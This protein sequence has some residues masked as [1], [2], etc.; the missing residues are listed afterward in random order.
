MYRTDLI[1]YYVNFDEEQRTGLIVG[2]SHDGAM[3]Q[4]NWEAFGKW[5]DEFARG[6]KPEERSQYPGSESR[7]VSYDHI[8][9]VVSNSP[10]YSVGVVVLQPKSAKIQP[11]QRTNK[12]SQNPVPPVAN[13]EN[14]SPTPLRMRSGSSQEIEIMAQC[15][16]FDSE[17][18]LVEIYASKKEAKA[19]NKGT[20]LV[21]IDAKNFPEGG[22]GEYETV[23]QL[24]PPK[25]K[26]VKADGEKRTRGPSASLTGQYTVVKSDAGRFNEEDARY[27][28]HKA[29]VENNNFEDYFAATPEKY[30][31]L[32]SGGKTV[33]D[34]P[35]IFA[36]YALRRGWISV[37]EVVV[38]DDAE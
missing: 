32:T 9:E 13:R 10:K 27:A 1:G 33:T 15:A 20:D 30:D 25:E 16:V 6:V 5:H 22:I 7:T 26:P 36:R 12:P 21:F 3:V 8:T 35:A 14:G 18:E 19:H 23:D 29:L 2:A 4:M 37:G 34:T 17:N 11:I 24:F 31:F 28:I 38:E